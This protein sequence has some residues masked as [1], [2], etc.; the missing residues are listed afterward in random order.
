[1]IRLH[2]V[3]ARTVPIMLALA[4]GP[5]VAEDAAGTVVVTLKG[6]HFFPDTVTVPAGQKLTLVFDNQDPT[7]EEIESHDLK[8]EKVVAA[9][10]SIRI[11]VGPLKA[12]EYRFVGEYHEDMAKGVLVVR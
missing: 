1:M 9:Q 8:I 2:S 10:K 3:L 12:G 5:V 11:S 4:A 7:P 6:H